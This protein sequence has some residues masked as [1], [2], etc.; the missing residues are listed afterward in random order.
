MHFS[1]LF[2]ALRPSASMAR[3]LS[4][5][6]VRAN[7]AIGSPDIPPPPGVIDAISAFA[8]QPDVSYKPSL[9]TVRARERLHQVVLNGAAGIDPTVN[10]LLCPGA[11][12]GIYLALKTLAH[13]G[14]KVALLQPHWL[15]Y[16]AICH[17]LGLPFVSIPSS[18]AGAGDD[19]FDV[20]ERL[21]YEGVS[22]LIVNNPNNPAGTCMSA[23]YLGSLI[24]RCERM[25][26][27]V[28]LDEVYK[29]LLFTPD[30]GL[31]DHVDLRSVVRVGSLSKSL[32]IPGLRIGYVAGSREFI[33]RADMLG[34]HLNTCV[35]SLAIA[36]AER[37]DRGE[38]LSYTE[39]CAGIYRSRFE[40]ARDVARV[41]GLPI[42]P[43]VASFYAMLDVSRR[44]GDGSEAAAQLERAG[45]I[46]TPGF[47]YGS[48]FSGFI[49]VCLTVDASRLAPCLEEICCGA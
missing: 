11:K 35:S 36:V 20:A 10:L 42:M 46:V 30:R 25:G 48:R 2:N 37:V 29:D 22:I 40:I 45:I 13:A 32:S 16:P 23:P 43:S 27:A 26:I 15:S 39:T 3:G 38:Y 17:A 19:A 41:H 5:V 7:L 44:Y 4:S 28:I 9:G 8:R 6:P 24:E 47:E 49:R 31:H 1:P 21:R 33:S 12:M 14:A 18:G 34:Q